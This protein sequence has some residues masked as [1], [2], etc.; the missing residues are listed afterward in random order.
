MALTVPEFIDQVLIHG[1]SQVQTVAGQHYLSFS[2]I[3]QGVEF[4]G[5]CID[6]HPFHEDGHSTTRFR[7]AIS[8]LFPA[9]YHPYNGRDLPFDL[10][11]NLRCGIVHAAV[12]TNEIE[13]IQREEIPQFGNH[14][15]IKNIRG[16][17]RLILV[18]QEY[19]QDFIGACEEIIDQIN[20]GT[21]TDTKLHRDFL[22][23][24][25]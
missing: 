17:D 23:V 18:S 21:L 6:T 9:T 1:I 19:L 15:E 2:L 25:P 10:Y 3:S 13:L 11:S 14:L 5:A 7:E 16:N 8:N 12:P 4:L 24:E 22:G 20:N